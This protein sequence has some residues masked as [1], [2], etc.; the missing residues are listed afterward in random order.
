MMLKLFQDLLIGKNNRGDLKMFIDFLVKRNILLTYEIHTKIHDENGKKIYL[1]FLKFKPYGNWYNSTFCLK[2]LCKSLD[3][4]NVDFLIKKFKVKPSNPLRL[5][6]YYVSDSE[7]L[8]SHFANFFKF[9]I[10]QIT[11]LRKFNMKNYEKWK[12]KH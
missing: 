1:M 8:I 4:E 12:C 2:T 9:K 7:E 3:I 11:H 5:N 6:I 10:W